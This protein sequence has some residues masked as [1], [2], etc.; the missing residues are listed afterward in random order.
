M[1]V[2]ALLAASG[3]A[4]VLPWLPQAPPSAALERYAPLRHGDS[5]LTLTTGA[6]GA[7][8][9]W[10]SG[11]HALV[12]PTRAFTTNLRS[13][14]AQA[15]RA[16]YGAD[17]EPASID[18]A[19][20]RLAADSA[21]VVKIDERELGATGL[22]TDSVMISLRSSR[23]D[24]V[25][26]FYRPD[27]DQ[28]LMFEPALPSL[29]A[30]LQPGRT[31]QAEGT[32]AGRIDY[33]FAGEVLSQ[34][35]YSG[36]AG[37]FTDC[38]QLET[39]LTLALEGTLLDDIRRRS[40][41][42]AG[43][44]GVESER[45]GEGDA[46]VTRTVL[47]S[48]SALKGGTRGE[49][50]PPPLLPQAPPPQGE[51]GSAAEWQ[52]ARLGRTLPTIS[53][54]SST[55]A[56]V[57]VPTDP[58]LVL[59]AA[60]DGAL[61]AFDAAD[62]MGRVRWR[63]RSGGTFFGQPAYDAATGRIFIGSSDKRLYALDSRG[64]YL[65]SFQADDNIAT[66]P[67]VAGGV[68]VF[69][70]EDR[71]V[72]GVDAASGRAVWER[73]FTTTGPVVSSP[74]VVGGVALIGSDDGQVYGLDVAT[75]Q[76]RWPPFTTEDAVEAPVVVADGMAYV[77]SRD[78]T[79]YALDPSTGEERW[80]GEAG[81][82]LRTAPAVGGGRAFVVD[83]LGFLKALDLESGRRL[84]MSAGD[85]YAGAPALVD[86][87]EDQPALVAARDDGVVELL[88]LDGA[89]LR[90]WQVAEVASPGEDAPG[91]AFG[92][93]AGSGALWLADDNGV[94]LRLG[95]PLAGPTPLRPAWYRSSAA[96]PFAG[97]EGHGLYY[98][99]AAYGG[100][101][102]A[103]D[104]GGNVYLVDPADGR[105][106]RLGRVEGLESIPTYAP[107]PAVAGDTLLVTGGGTLGALDL[108][109]GQTLW[110]FTPEGEARSVRPA[111]AAGDAALWL[112]AGGESGAAGTLYA[113]DLADGSVRWMVGLD[114]FL[115][116]GGA[117]A[118][119]DVVY[120][121]TP[122]A[123]FDLATGR[124][125]WRADVPGQP[126][127]G[128][129][130]SEDGGTLY[131]A[132]TGDPAGAVA[133]LDTSDGS[134]RWVKELDTALGF[135]ERL[136]LSGEMLIVPAYDHQIV[137]LDA[138]DGSERWRARPGRRWGAAT[139]VGGYVW[140]TD[141]DSHVALLDVRDGSLAHFYSAVDANLEIGGPAAGRPA[142]VG[143]QII[144]PYS[145]ALIAFEVPR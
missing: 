61:V 90:E 22:V 7:P 140:Q 76:E 38:V 84:W 135:H 111:T 45:L 48:S 31:W 59:A 62:P 116:A 110:S 43:A 3:L 122:P 63:F 40:W 112:V 1:A 29:P 33:T 71:T 32:L 123:A 70:S 23:G 142:E 114:G 128:T 104:S 9:G 20:V 64:I 131:V 68:V 117:V 95:T 87:G 27:G 129:V 65:W 77:A 115:A 12:P 69:G 85:D 16:H 36:P 141:V 145:S 15:L 56:P 124:E 26:G 18:E 103:L 91:L 10:T 83:E 66:R 144:L 137:A 60:Y 74:A 47:V 143:G 8:Q 138:G 107:D 41:Q 78:G 113:L 57:W 50:P 28:D 96:A 11:T 119:G 49:P 34:G 75:G 79:V 99:P 17:G 52:L 118:R 14:Q 94:L 53:S 126:L 132:M 130:L 37:D 82:A 92:P 105:A 13:A 5:W 93:S 67:A 139:V 6:D 106:E 80:R 44:G 86:A 24:F 72:Y 2:L 109:D 30:E 73:A 133:A 98:T 81:N 127:G 101:A 89:V 125:L 134:V 51:M 21:S 4:F 25:L 42:C 97:E 136:W 121:S 120:T 54:G 19:M 100:Q 46:L 88:D 108:R 102:V 55:F 58:P 35:A 39:R